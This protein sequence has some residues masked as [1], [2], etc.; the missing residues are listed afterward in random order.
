MKRFLF[1]LPVLLLMGCIFERPTYHIYY[2][3]NGSTIGNPPVDSTVYY[4]GDTATILD[5]GNLSN[6]DYDFLGWKSRD[7]YYSLY[8]PGEQ[9]TMIWEDI[10][11]Y[12]VWDDGTDTPFSFVI[13]D[14]EVIITR[15][16]EDYASYYILIPETLQSKPVT[17]I[18]D[19]V[20]SNLSICQVSLPR[21]LKRIGA[22]T[23]ASNNIAQIIIPDSVETIGAAAFWNNSLTK[24]ML[25]NGLEAI[26]P[27]TFR[28]NLL[29]E[30]TIPE[31]IASIG[32]GAF[33]GNDIEMVKIGAGV[34]IGSDTSMGTYGATFRTYYDEQEKQ[35]GF[36]L[37]IDDDTW[38]RL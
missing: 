32:A 27:Y 11:L 10:N 12:P 29:I 7:Y 8:Y 9:I 15:Y 4:G 5:K 20:F 26:E 34:T 17:A 35:A 3:G 37:Y 19:T 23:F 25:G 22:A 6:G 18:N 1:L 13:I 33:Y 16:N 36:Y 28:N 24:V 30:V 2:H 14:G 31:N 38:E 21:R